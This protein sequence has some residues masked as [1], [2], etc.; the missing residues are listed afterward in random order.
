MNFQ[1]Q[2]GRPIL[3]EI[4][5]VASYGEQNIP[6]GWLV[7]DGREI[8]AA[9]FPRLWNVCEGATPDLRDATLRGADD[10]TPPMNLVGFNEPRLPVVN[11]V[12]RL[13]NTD[14]ADLDTQNIDVVSA[15]KT[16]AGKANRSGSADTAYITCGTST[17][18]TKL[19]SGGAIPL[20]DS[21]VQ[22]GASIDVRG[23]RFGVIF[24][25]WAIG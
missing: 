24:I 25:I 10:T 13:A 2:I 9:K 18:P 16:L 7:C 12:H 22:N 14:L 17:P 6:Y 15:D 1:S 4:R 23:R 8:D 21:P 20:D 3:G 11:H 19:T 5:A